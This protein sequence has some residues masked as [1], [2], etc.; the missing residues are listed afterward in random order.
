MEKSHRFFPPLSTPDLPKKFFSNPFSEGREKVIDASKNGKP[1]SLSSDKKALTKNAEFPEDSCSS[2]VTDEVSSLENN[3]GSIE[4]NLENKSRICVAIRVRPVLEADPDKMPYCNRVVHVNQELSS[5]RIMKGKVGQEFKFS[6]CFDSHSQQEDVFN[7]LSEPLITQLL[8]GINCTLMA[9]GQTGSGKTYSM[10]GSSSNP[11]IIPRICEKLKIRLCENDPKILSKLKISYYEI[12]NEKIYDLLADGDK[13]CSLK[14][15]EDPKTGAFVDGLRA[16]EV[17]KNADILHLI[18]VGNK[19]RMM[20]AT[21]NNNH[22]SRSHVIL[23]LKLV[24][25]DSSDKILYSLLNLVDLAGSESGATSERLDETSSINK[26]LHCLGRVIQQLRNGNAHISYRDSVLTRL[27][28]ESLGGNALTTLLATITPLHAHI[29]QTLNTLRYA[30]F[31]REVV[32][33]VQIN[34]TSALNEKQLVAAMLQSKLEYEHKIKELYMLLRMYKNIAVGQLNCDFE[35]VSDSTAISEKALTGDSMTSLNT[36][37]AVRDGELDVEVL[38]SPYLLWLS[39]ESDLNFLAISLPLKLGSNKIGCDSAADIVVEGTMLSGVECTVFRSIEDVIHVVPEN[40]KELYVNGKQVTTLTTLNYGD[41]LCLA[42]EHFL[43]LCSMNTVPKLNPGELQ[44]AKLEFLMSQN[45]RLILQLANTAAADVREEIKETDINNQTP[46]KANFAIQTDSVEN[47]QMVNKPLKF[48]FSHLLNHNLNAVLDLELFVREANYLCKCW[49]V[50]YSFTVQCDP[51]FESEIPTLTVVMHNDIMKT[52]VELSA[53]YFNENWLI[54][55]SWQQSKKRNKFNDQIAK[56]F[57]QAKSDGSSHQ[58]Q[59]LD[60]HTQSQGETTMWEQS[61]ENGTSE[62]ASILSEPSEQNKIVASE[63]WDSFAERNSKNCTNSKTILD[64]FLLS[65]RNF[66]GLLVNLLK[67]NDSEGCYLSIRKKGQLL[68]SFQNLHIYGQVMAEMPNSFPESASLIG[69][70]DKAMNNCFAALL[71]FIQVI[72]NEEFVTNDKVNSVIRMLLKVFEAVGCLCFVL[73]T[74]GASHTFKGDCSNCKLSESLYGALF[75]GLYNGFK[76]M[77]AVV[78]NMIDSESSHIQRGQRETLRRMCL[79]KAI[80]K[81][82]LVLKECKRNSECT[83]QAICSSTFQIIRPMM[84]SVSSAAGFSDPAFRAEAVFN[85]KQLAVDLEC[86]ISESMKQTCWNV[87]QS[88]YPYLSDLHSESNNDFIFKSYSVELFS[89][90]NRLTLDDVTSFM[91]VFYDESIEG[92]F[93]DCIGVLIPSRNSTTHTDIAVTSRYC[94]QSE[95]FENANVMTYESFNQGYGI[96]SVNKISQIYLLNKNGTSRSKIQAQPNIAVIKLQMPIAFT[97]SVQPICLPEVNEMITD[98]HRCYFYRFGRI[99]N[100]VSYFMPLKMKLLSHEYCKRI[101]GSSRLDN[102]TQF[103]WKEHSLAPILNTE[104][105]YNMIPDGSSLICRKGGLFYLLGIQDWIRLP[106]PSEYIHPVVIFT[107]V[108]AFIDSSNCGRRGLPG[109]VLAYTVVFFGEAQG[110]MF[111]DCIATLVPSLNYSFSDTVVTSRYCVLFNFIQS[112]KIAPAYLFNQNNHVETSNRVRRILFLN[113]QGTNRS[114]RQPPPNISVIKMRLPILINFDIQPVCLPKEYD[115][116]TNEQQCLYYRFFYVEGTTLLFLPISMKQISDERCKSILGNSRKDNISQM[117]F[118]EDSPVALFNKEFVESLFCGSGYHT[119]DIGSYTVI[120]YGETSEG[121]FIDCTGMLIPSLNSNETH[122]DTVI[123]TRYCLQSENHNNFNVMPMTLFQQMGPHEDNKIL[124]V[125]FP[126]KKDTGRSKRQPQPNIAIVK[127]RNS[128]RISSSSLPFCLPEQNEVLSP[129]NNNCI[130]YRFGWFGNVVAFLPLKMNILS[131][132]QCKRNVGN[133]EIDNSSQICCEE[134]SSDTSLDTDYHK[135]MIPD[136]FPLICLKN[137]TAYLYGMQDWLRTKKADHFSSYYFQNSLAFCGLELDIGS[138]DSYLVIFYGRT[139]EGIF[140][141]CVGSIVPSNANDS[142]SDIIITSRNCI[143]P[144][145]VNSTRVLPF[146][147]Y[148]HD[149]YTDGYKIHRVIFLTH[150]SSSGRMRKQNIAV[151]KLQSA[152]AFSPSVSPLCLPNEGDFLTE[153][154]ECSFFEIHQV[155]SDIILFSFSMKILSIAE[156]N[157]FLESYSYQE[158]EKICA[159]EA[160]NSLEGLSLVTEVYMVDEGTP[161]ICTVENIHY[162]FGIKDWIK[163]FKPDKHLP[164]LVIFSAIVPHLKIINDFET[165]LNST[166]STTLSEDIVAAECGSSYGAVNVGAYITVFYTS[167][168]DG[169]FVDCV[170]MI[171]SSNNSASSSKFVLT[172]RY[173]LEPD[174][175]GIRLFDP[176]TQIC[177]EEI[178][179]QWN[180]QVENK[181]TLIL[182]GSPLVCIKDSKHYLYG[183]YSWLKI[184]KMDFP[185]TVSVECGNEFY[186]EDSRYFMVVFY[187]RTNEGVFFDCIGAIVESGIN[188]THSDLII[189]SKYCVDLED[190]KKTFVIPVGSYPPSN[191]SESYKIHRILLPLKDDRKSHKNLAVVKLLTPITFDYLTLP[192]CL[193]EKNETFDNSYDCYYFEFYAF[194]NEMYMTS[195]EVFILQKEYCNNI[196]GQTVLF[197]STQLCAVQKSLSDIVESEDPT[198]I[199]E[200]LPLICIKNHRQYLYAIRDWIKVFKPEKN[201]LPV[202]ILTETSNIIDLIQHA[203]VLQDNITYLHGADIMNVTSK[204][205]GQKDPL[206]DAPTYMAVFYGTTQ[207]GLF[208]DCVGAFIS[209]EDNATSSNLVITTKYCIQ[210]E[211]ALLTNVLPMNYFNEQ[212]FSY[213]LSIR[214]IFFPESSAQDKNKTLP[215]IAIVEL[216]SR[217]HFDGKNASAIPDGSP[218]ICQRNMQYYLYGIQDW[219]ATFMCGQTAANDDGMPHYA[220]FYAVTEEGK[221]HDC[222]GIIADSDSNFTHSDTIITSRYCL[223]EAD[224][225]A[226]KVLPLSKYVEE[227]FSDG[228]SNSKSNIPNIAIIKLN[229]PISYAENILPMCLPNKSDTLNESSTCEIAEIYIGDEDVLTE[230][231]PLVCNIQGRRYLYGVRD[232]VKEF[233][234]EPYRL[235]IVV[236]TFIPPL[237]DFIKGNM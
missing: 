154:S 137:E 189:T 215:N 29:E 34:E 72:K 181:P 78:G 105:M 113:S 129:S 177:C 43:K 51:G 204:I 18:A 112:T 161:L 16:I 173:C 37:T 133:V 88:I 14:V 106:K 125:Y 175:V 46:S 227:N 109:D 138:S 198:L 140:I 233:R 120:F 183:I 40:G 200:G 108:S 156:C 110:R 132:E 232:F 44:D 38:D 3:N 216:E 143:N 170:G 157:N 235:P 236:V 197:D 117:C 191:A 96:G 213:G 82:R 36:L 168:T 12:Y 23:S 98:E 223:S 22:S 53:D 152:I 134:Q 99:G 6:H 174:V 45:Q 201:L 56:M 149:N 192:I 111:V 66:Y 61:S 190:I 24:Q 202:L 76:K 49:N 54:L 35:S 219:E 60:P 83:N 90:G 211:N 169:F 4:D 55:R 209:V 158:N 184:Q 164:P 68:V 171:V 165:L 228:N 5:I 8:R 127:L 186:L 81:L 176:K 84:H 146:L 101:I 30:N 199:E 25:N 159:K 220:V 126:N 58:H 31:A 217:V 182:E 79:F 226:T 150:N 65:A 128:Y 131:H 100:T 180:L 63:T 41:R 32:N 130:F 1:E 97:D 185:I 121:V 148:N 42:G 153:D 86:I 48:D 27:L 194:P 214:H 93:L 162:L 229:Q 218:L 73:P 7:E 91:I 231:S 89:C 237:V 207:E 141:D 20:A 139:Q 147:S 163:I 33:Y 77:A 205:C 74:V 136:G 206:I 203:N 71:T 13:T 222:M 26:S 92:L 225:S 104:Y 17:D 57:Y 160:Y 151:V 195:I 19:R 144:N 115:Y 47:F 155:A 64:W 10:M 172:S 28:K 52:D 230:G 122:V 196:V 179:N 50:P 103:C 87:L 11:G 9:Y 59:M 75:K 224:I 187:G 95:N 94:L 193:P 69:Q 15:R 221:F 118:E 119:D 114:R 21:R 166:S 145:E 85:L 70:F 208:K 67:N 178:Q 123:T 188:S 102:S 116:P 107:A 135:D 80:E 2:C 234:K 212:Y 167:T 210:Q 62:S 124:H 142:F 39:S